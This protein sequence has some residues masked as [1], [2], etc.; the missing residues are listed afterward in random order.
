MGNEFNGVQLVCFCS[1]GHGAAGIEITAPQ[2]L[3]YF[4]ELKRGSEFKFE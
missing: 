4:N 1:E 3:A 2:A